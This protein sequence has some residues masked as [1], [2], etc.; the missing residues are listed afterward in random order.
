VGDPATVARKMWHISD[1][2]GGVERISLMM[3]GGPLPHE[4]LLHAIELLG[5]QVKPLVTGKAG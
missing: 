5:T 1:S 4:K 2:L 3:S